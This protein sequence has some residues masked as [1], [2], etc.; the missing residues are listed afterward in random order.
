MNDAVVGMVTCPTRA[1][2]RKVAK[3]I[4]TKKLAACVNIVGGLESHYWWNGK[5]EN[6]HE[7]LLLIKTTRARTVDVTRTVKAVHSYEVP[8]VIFLPILSGE[9]NYL[10]WLR[11]SVVKAAAVLLLLGAVGT[12]RADQVDDLVKQLG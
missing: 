7:H 8:E 4:L 11:G 12:A 1:E 9:R 6:A 10:K 5:L 2:A 3:A